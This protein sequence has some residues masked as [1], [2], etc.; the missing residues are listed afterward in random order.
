MSQ[1]SFTVHGNT[2]GGHVQG[3]D[4][5]EV[6]RARGVGVGSGVGGSVGDGMASALDRRRTWEAALDEGASRIARPPRARG[7]PASQSV[8]VAAPV[9][10]EYFPASQSVQVASLVAPVLFEYFPASQ[11]VQVALLVAPVADEYFPA[12]QPV[13]DAEPTADLNVPAAH[14]VHPDDAY[15]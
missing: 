12:P 2:R 8:Q 7:P 4:D 14:I 6:C 5:E 15:E 10:D 3:V 1:R 9:L 13:H 11:S